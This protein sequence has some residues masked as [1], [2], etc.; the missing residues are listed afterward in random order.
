MNAAHQRWAWKGDIDD[1]CYGMSHKAIYPLLKQW[2]QAMASS[3]QGQKATIESP[4]EMVDCL[5]GGR[6]GDTGG[7]RALSSSGDEGAA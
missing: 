4:G 2:R 3:G 5:R 1:L 6:V 7:Q